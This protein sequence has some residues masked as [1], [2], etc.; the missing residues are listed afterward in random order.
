MAVFPLQLNDKEEALAH[1]RKVSYMLARNTKDLEKRLQ[2]QLE[3]LGLSHKDIKTE[4]SEESEWSRRR[5]CRCS[6]DS[7]GSQHLTVP[8][9]PAADDE[10]SS[11]LNQPSTEINETDN[12][13]V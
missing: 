7:C 10:Q 12:K 2:M 11:K 4:A 5:D 1:Q 13:D 6:A 3:E 8:D 9:S